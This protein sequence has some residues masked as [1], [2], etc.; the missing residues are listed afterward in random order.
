MDPVRSFRAPWG[1]L[2]IIMTALG[3]VVLLG[4]PSMMVS[5]IPQDDL[6]VIARIAMILIWPLILGITALFS[7]RSFDIMQDGIL[8]QRLF[9]A[10]RLGYEDLRSVR[11]DKDAMKGSIRVMGNGGLF[12][13]SG[14]YRSRKLGVFT[15]YATD[16]KLSV[17][18]RYS[19]RT[20]VVTPESPEEFADLVR[21]F[22]SAL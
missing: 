9:W 4:V 15:V 8:V 19:D 7:I 14:R 20:V 18:L 21:Q 1:K 6:P 3:C 16:M 17:I 5:V 13:F 10:N 11:V 2:L 12:S 22:S